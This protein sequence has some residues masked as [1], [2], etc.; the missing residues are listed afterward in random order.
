MNSTQENELIEKIANLLDNYLETEIE[1]LS[2]I[3]KMVQLEKNEARLQQ[4]KQAWLDEING[5]SK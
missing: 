4:E 5:G 2:N 3:D 1:D